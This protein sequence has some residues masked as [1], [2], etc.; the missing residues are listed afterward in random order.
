MGIPPEE[1][2]RGIVH[3]LG[4]AT[5]QASHAVYW[6]HGKPRRADPQGLDAANGQRL[7]ALSA[8]M[9]GLNWEG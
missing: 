6:R 1:A 7:W 9:C 2:A 8:Q 4:E 3:L 5:L